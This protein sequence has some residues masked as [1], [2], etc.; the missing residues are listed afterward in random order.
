LN[1]FTIA[2]STG[3]GNYDEVERPLFRAM[4]LESDFD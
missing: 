2:G 4:T 3:I 1:E